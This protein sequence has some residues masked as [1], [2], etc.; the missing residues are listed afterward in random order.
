MNNCLKAGETPVPASSV[1]SN[2]KKDDDDD[3]MA[4]LTRQLN[5]ISAAP[6]PANYSPVSTIYGGPQLPLNNNEFGAFPPIS[7]QFGIPS[8]I[9]NNQYRTPQSMSNSQYGASQSMGY[10]STVTNPSINL[11]PEASVPRIFFLF[12]N[13]FKHLK[14]ILE[15][16]T[17]LNVESFLE[18]RKHVK[19][20]LSA[21][22]YE[23]SKTALE[24][25][26]KAI[27]LLQKK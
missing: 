11:A 2:A 22:D 26:Y 20:A 5:D 18:A 14:K 19:Y 27:G 6:V 23:D 25:L 21:I 15:P 16:A 10:P 1:N 4:E 3:G 12:L 17:A 9:P 7:N 8:Q 24:N 13:F